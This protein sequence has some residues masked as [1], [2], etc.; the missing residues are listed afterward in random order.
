MTNNALPLILGE[1]WFCA[2]R[3]ELH[4]KP[5]QPSEIHQPSTKTIIQCRDQLMPRMA[6]AV[7]LTISA[8]SHFDAPDAKADALQLAHEPDEN[9]PLWSKL[10]KAAASE[11]NPA[12]TISCAVTKLCSPE[13]P[14]SP[15]SSGD[16]DF[17]DIV[18]GEQLVPEQ[19]DAVK[20]VVEKHADIF[21]WS[22]DDIGLYEGIEHEIK[23][24]P[25]AQPYGRQPYRYT[26]SDRIFLENQTATLLSKDIIR[27]TSGPW[28][29]PAL[30]VTQGDKK[31]L[32]VNYMALNQMTVSVLQPLPRADDIFDDIGGA[33][34][35]AVLDLCCAYWQIKVK[36][37]DQDKTTF[38]THQGTF[39]WTRMPFG[40]KNAPATFQKAMHKIFSQLKPRDSKSGV[41]TYLDDVIMFANSEE[42][43]DLL[44]E[45]LTLL[46]QAGLKAS[47][48]KC[49]FAVPSV[50]FL[51]F[52]ISQNG[53]QPDPAKIEAILRIPTPR[54]PKQLL[55]WVQTAN[56]YRRFI[57][58]FF[59]ICAPLQ[60]AMR[61][62]D[63]KWTPECEESFQTIR[64]ALT[65]AP[66]L[67]HF[68]RNA[69][70]TVAT[71]ASAT[72]LGAVLTQKQ[73]GKEVVLEYASRSLTESERKLHSNVW[74]ALA[75]HW[76][77]AV[78]FRHY[79]LG[80]KFHLLT[81]NWSVA[82][83]TRNFKPSRRFTGIL[84]DLAEFEFSVEHR[85]GRQN[86]VADM[87]SR[88]S[89]AALS[90][91]H[92]F[93]AMQNADDFCKS[94]KQKVCAEPNSAGPFVIINDILYRVTSEGH[95]CPVVPAKIQ[96]SVLELTHDASGHSDIKRTMDKLQGRFW[97]PNMLST[98]TSYVQACQRCQE[99]NRPTSRN[100][101]KME[102]MPTTDVPFSSIAMDHITMPSSDKQSYIL[103]VIDFA[104]RYI[105]PKPVPNTSTKEVI[106]HLHSVFHRFGTP[107][108]CLSDHGKAFDS[109]EFK[110]FMRMHG[111]TVHYSVAYRAASN[112]LVERSNGTLVTVL[113]K[114]CNHDQSQWTKKLDEAAFAV[115]TS[116]N[117][118]TGFSPFEL[119]YGYTPNL[120]YQTI[121]ASKPTSVQERLLA[122]QSQRAEAASNLENAEQARKAYYDRAHRDHSYKVGDFVWVRR[123][124]PLPHVSEKLA[125]RFKGVY[126]ILEK[127]TPVTYLVTQVGRNS[128]TPDS[129]VVHVSQIKLFRPPYIDPI[130]ASSE[131]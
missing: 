67:G 106:R 41:R 47:L 97:W 84:L 129:R 76:A 70:T 66:I 130:L 111:V 17:T 103:N 93:T 94:T 120:P 25:D 99:D 68:D 102:F 36:E 1:D 15:S 104:T 98:V 119:M 28:G 45:T 56:F 12:P 9:E 82:C 16:D 42:F 20:R 87:L 37:E 8:L 2:A 116:L 92:E 73:A 33:S 61:S 72:A 131:A 60:A 65:S 29:F 40:L 63:F 89:C 75:V 31:R 85:P 91:T 19:H 52:L 50:K 80:R 96:Q 71:D 54:T 121:H 90:Q 7:I 110:N 122:L 123:Q 108:D 27:P 55:S 48:K 30:V 100:V 6:N 112:G 107:S 51:G 43:L 10:A 86:Y 18:L 109:K 38:I 115:N 57:P 64:S 22:P 113:R 105:V 95:H 78:K 23:L 11:V 44:D 49:K 53:K 5:P 124:Q 21:T 62:A 74:E 127:K 34:L 114:M 118:S 128:G 125:P 32:C 58:G 81:D 117:S 79:L 126:Q 24:K 69:P 46:Q 88:H 77:I 83:L 3:A 35:F 14:L 26:A 13:A 39:K 101:G 4:V 59:K